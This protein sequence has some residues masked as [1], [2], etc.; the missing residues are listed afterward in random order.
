MET[1]PQIP[2]AIPYPVHTHSLPYFAGWHTIPPVPA[3]LPVPLSVPGAGS[4]STPV[5][6]DGSASVSSHPPRHISGSDQAVSPTHTD[7]RLCHTQSSCNP[8]WSCR[9]RFSLC[10]GKYRDRDSHAP[11]NLPVSVRRNS[12][13]AHPRKSSF[14]FSVS[15]FPHQKCRSLSARRI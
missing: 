11:H 5:R 6:P 12:G 8:A 13:Y 4:L 14:S 2:A 15:S 7:C 10:R 9:L 3:P 1:F